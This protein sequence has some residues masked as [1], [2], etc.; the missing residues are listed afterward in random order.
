MNAEVRSLYRVA[1]ARKIAICIIKDNDNVYLI[2]ADGIFL[3]YELGTKSH[4]F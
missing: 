2:S 3:L 1:L 4:K